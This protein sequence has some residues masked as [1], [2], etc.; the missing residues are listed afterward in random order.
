MA[1]LNKQRQRIRSPIKV[2]L[3]SCSVFPF[4]DY[5]FIVKTLQRSSSV[6]LRFTKLYSKSTTSNQYFFL[7]SY[8][9]EWPTRGAPATGNRTRENW[10]KARALVLLSET[11]SFAAS[12]FF[13]SRVKNIVPT[14][15]WLELFP[16]QRHGSSSMAPMGTGKHYLVKCRLSSWRLLFAVNYHCKQWV[17]Q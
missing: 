15:D 9:I 5:V 2:Q 17:V 3:T 12:D 11:Q 16:P 14:L 6:K 8:P 1:G 13:Y 10:C 7:L 4:R